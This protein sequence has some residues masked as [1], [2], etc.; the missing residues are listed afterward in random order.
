MFAIQSLNSNFNPQKNLLA[1][2]FSFANDLG[3]KRF[4]A[5]NFIAYA[6][7]ESVPCV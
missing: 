7:T 3:E 5:K 1:R 6:L 4:Q 2:A